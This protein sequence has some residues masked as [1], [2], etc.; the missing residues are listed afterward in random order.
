MVCPAPAVDSPAAPLHV[1]PVKFHCQKRTGVQ[2]KRRL[3]KRRNVRPDKRFFSAAAKGGFQK[4]G[5][6]SASWNVPL[7]ANSSPS[8]GTKKVNIA[9]ALEPRVPRLPMG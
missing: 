6:L 5:H 3:S 4:E 1:G 7:V 9:A 2:R 8:A